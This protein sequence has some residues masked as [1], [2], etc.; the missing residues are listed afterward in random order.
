MAFEKKIYNIIQMKSSKYLFIV[1][2][3]DD[4]VLGFGGIIAKLVEQGN[5]VYVT[6]LQAPNNDRAA[7][8]IYD[9]QSAKDVLGYQYLN[10]L[11]IP[12]NVLC[13]DM[14][15]L[16]HTIQNHLKDIEPAVL[17]TTH[18]SDNHQDHKN[19]YRAVSIATRPI[20][21]CRTIKKIYTGEV[22]SSYDQSFSVERAAFMPN[23]YEELTETQLSKKINALEKYTTEVQK[24]P[25][26]RNKEMLRAKSIVRGA[27]CGVKYAEA[28]MLLRDVR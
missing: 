23:I 15:S 26:P 2:H 3:A 11:Y 22:I 27:E 12:N 9:A 28:F 16:L 19:L 5:E 17:Y 20:G 13:N 1:P 10:F 8:Q 21:Q 14:F 25:H 6:I 7:Q 24:F 4:E 18:F